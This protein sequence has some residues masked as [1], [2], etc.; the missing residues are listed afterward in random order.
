MKEEKLKK[1]SNLQDLDALQFQV[2]TNALNVLFDGKSPKYQQRFKSWA[3]S[4]HGEHLD[5]LVDALLSSVAYIIATGKA[6]DIV[7]MDKKTT[8]EY[9][10][11]Q[12]QGILTL[13][14]WIRQYASET[15][16][17]TEEED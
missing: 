11:G 12:V 17:T 15:K 16:I 10:Q 7:G 4:V 6:E 14:N 3:K 13:Q 2:K 9:L 1:S 5:N 8:I